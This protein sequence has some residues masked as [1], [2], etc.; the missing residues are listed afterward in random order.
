MSAIRFG[1]PW[2]TSLVVVSALSVAVLV[3]VAV[4]FALFFPQ[5]PLPLLKLLVVLIPAIVLVG[6]ALFTVRAY[7]VSGPDELGV[8]RLLWTTWLPLAGLRKAWADPAA[9]SRSWRLFGNGGLFSITGLFWN[10]RL[11]R[12]RAFATDP[13]RAVVLRFGSRTVV[14]TPDEPATFVAELARRR[15]WLGTTGPTT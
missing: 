11:G 15:H 2:S 5:G 1:A 8:R 4:S 13:R 12:Y 10:R 14:V 9:M 7:E 3:A 6:S